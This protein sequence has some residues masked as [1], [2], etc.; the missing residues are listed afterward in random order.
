MSLSS[1]RV[2]LRKGAWCMF[3]SHTTFL[4]NLKKVKW[5]TL[6]KKG[7]W[8]F[9]PWS[10]HLGAGQL[11]G[12][13]T[14]SLPLPHGVLFA[15]ISKSTTQTTHSTS[16]LVFKELVENNLW[17]NKENSCDFKAPQGKGTSEPMM[18][19][20]DKDNHLIYILS[21]LLRAES[22]QL[23]DCLVYPIG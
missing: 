1:E 7:C 22:G 18:T 17:R 23:M 21:L 11:K 5:R 4:W 6:Y 13:S 15:L 3:A 12:D 8:Q 10:R 14:P 20:F 9:H 2:L 16:I 19:W